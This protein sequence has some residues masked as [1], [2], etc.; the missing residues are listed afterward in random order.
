MELIIKIPDDA[1]KTG[2]TE[3]D[4]IAYFECCT[5]KL[6]ETLKSAVVLPEHHGDLVDR[7]CIHKAIYASDDNC[8]GMGMS[9]DEM[10]F[11]NEGINSMWNELQNA[12]P[13]I[14]ADRGE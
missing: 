6:F 10:D 12:D 5:P 9:Y 3:N 7:N 4:V 14:E 2:I 1:I 13:I 8:T 11:Y